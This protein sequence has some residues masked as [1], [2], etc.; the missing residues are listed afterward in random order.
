MFQS[1][2][3]LVVGAGASKEAN[4][5]TGNELTNTIADKLDIRFEDYKKI[6]GDD[7]ITDALR[8]H[9]QIPNG[10]PGDIN[11]YLHAG[12]RIRD[13][14]PQALS[15]DS[16]IDAHEGDEKIELCGKLAIVRCILAAERSSLLFSGETHP[17]STLRF[18]N[19]QTTW[20]NRFMQLLTEGC[21][22]ENIADGIARVSFITFNYDRCIEYFLFHSLQNYY[23]IP[24][25]EAAELVGR[26][27]IFHP[28]GVVGHLPW[29]SPEGAVP[30]GGKTSGATLLSLSSQIKTFT[31]RV[32]DEAIITEIRQLMSDANIVIFLGF[33][34]HS[35]NMELIK[36]LN[37]GNVTRVFATAK[38]IS[39]SDSKIVIQQILQCFSKE[40][41]RF[42]VDLNRHATCYELFQEYWRSLVL[43]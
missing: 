24:N 12:L 11:P 18:K 33:A 20:Y 32:E 2:T 43:S 3:L 16:F 4:M 15:I 35:Q 17:E 28:Y 39:D 37:P 25:T 34:F 7:Y 8:R 9:V 13:A 29:Q 30:F 42:Q 5:P 26:L 6:S 31:E 41:G 1:N 36:P 19:L 22:K 27:K 38:G 23:G 14:M 10:P 40:N 21:R